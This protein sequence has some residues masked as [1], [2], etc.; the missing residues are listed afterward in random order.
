MSARDR[1]LAKLKANAPATASSAHRRTAIF[2]IVLV[3]L[4]Q[5]Y[6]FSQE[7]SKKG[8]PNEINPSAGLRFAN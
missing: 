5:K 8:R 6:D 1:I 2:F 4:P 3:V 7:F